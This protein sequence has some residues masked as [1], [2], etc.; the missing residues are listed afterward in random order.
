MHCRQWQ[1]M[2][3]VW[4]ISSLLSTPNSEGIKR[5]DAPPLGRLIALAKR[6]VPRPD[7]SAYDAV[8]RGT[9]QLTG[10]LQPDKRLD[11]NDRSGREAADQELPGP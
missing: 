9:G 1:C 7:A 2:L 8:P 11:A 4:R 10:A 5:C 6:A 3:C